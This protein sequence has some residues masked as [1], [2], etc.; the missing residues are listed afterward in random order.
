MGYAEL[1]YSL[2]IEARYN[3]K[4]LVNKIASQSTK[5]GMPQHTPASTGFM[6]SAT[7]PNIRTSSIPTNKTSRLSTGRSTVTRPIPQRTQVSAP[8]TPPARKKMPSEEFSEIVDRVKN[9][10]ETPNKP[11]NKAG[12]KKPSGMLS[13]LKNRWNKLS[14]TGKLATGGAVAGGAYMLNRMRKPAYEQ[15]QSSGGRGTKFERHYR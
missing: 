12:D 2:L 15:Q 5:G 1:A 10:G 6:R 7:N 4:R 13:G 11:E 9:K 8:L 3:F 14:T